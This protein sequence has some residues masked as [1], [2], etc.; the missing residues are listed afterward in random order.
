LQHEEGQ[1]QAQRCDRQL[2]DADREEPGQRDTGHAQAELGHVSQ[3]GAAPLQRQPI[4]E[5]NPRYRRHAVENAD[6]RH[7]HL[8]AEDMPV[9]PGVGPDVHDAVGLVGS[10][11]IEQVRA[12][13]QQQDH[14]DATP[15]AA[16]EPHFRSAAG[17]RV[18]RHVAASGEIGR[19]AD[20]HTDTGG[21]EAEVP[22]YFLTQRADNQRRRQ[23]ADVKRDQV[24]AEGTRATQVL[25]RVK[26]PDLRRH[27]ADH[28]ARSD[29]R[30][31]QCAEEGRL[32]GHGQMPGG[33]QQTADR[34]CA[35]AS[36][37]AVA[38]PRAGDRGQVDHSRIDAVGLT[39][40]R[41]VAELADHGFEP[42]AIGGEAQHSARMLWQQQVL[43][44]V[45]HEQRL[46]SVER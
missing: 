14:S 4:A 29:Y 35:R 1:P 26:Q 33:H 42:R 2:G 46:H 23:R 24:D 27:V 13:E 32:V 17:D 9:D 22:R 10:C 3:F 45:E 44:H 11:E 28:A 37:H 21:A 40:E 12:E 41:Q 31:R 34:D 43:G 30:E 19:K 39:R 36:E 38:E 25:G 15:F 7:R 18:R 16:R 8:P 5:P 6:P 20:E